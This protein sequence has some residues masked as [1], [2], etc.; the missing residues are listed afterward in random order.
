MADR[1]NFRSFDPAP[2]GEAFLNNERRFRALI[3]EA[4]SV[5]DLTI[6]EFNSIVSDGGGL[7][8]CCGNI[9]GGRPDSIFGGIFCPVDGGTP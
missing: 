2:A 9:D 8:G 4:F 5:V 6:D 1:T 7:G 3:E